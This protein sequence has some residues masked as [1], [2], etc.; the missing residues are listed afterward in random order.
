MLREDLLNTLY[1]KRTSSAEF[2]F[3][4]L[5]APNIH[6]LLTEYD[7]ARIYDITTSVK[8]SSKVAMKIKAIREILRPR[9]F[10]QFAN[11]TNRMCFRFLEDK[12]IVLKVAYK[13]SGLDNGFR[14]MYN[15]QFLKPFVSKTFEVHPSGTVS[16]HE[17]L[18]PITNKEEFLSVI[19]DIF[20]VLTCL[21]G[22]YALE[23]VGTKYFMNWGIRS[24]F[25]V[26]IL[27]YPDL[28]EL[29]G[30]KLY[31]N[32]PIYP[33]TK[34]P[35]C[36]GL[37][38]YDKGFNTLVC[39]CCGKEYRAS[40]LQKARENK[41]IILEGDV[42]MN[43]RIL[44]GNQVVAQSD[45]ISDVIEKPQ[46]F[47]ER[48]STEL[49]PRIIRVNPQPTY[50]PETCQIKEDIKSEGSVAS[51]ATSIPT[52]EIQKPAPKVEGIDPRKLN[53]MLSKYQGEYN[54]NDEDMMIVISLLY[55][56]GVDVSRLTDDHIRSILDSYV[57]AKKDVE[58]SNAVSNNIE[59]VDDEYANIKDIDEVLETEVK[60]EAFIQECRDTTIIID[61]ISNDIVEYAKAVWETEKGVDLTKL[62]KRQ[63][64]T[65]F[66][67]ILHA[68]YMR[69]T[70]EEAANAII[71]YVRNEKLLTPNPVEEDQN[72]DTPKQENNTNNTATEGIKSKFIPT[73]EN[74]DNY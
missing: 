35:V 36:N 45:N 27:D 7:I 68:N 53:D 8:Y 50:K 72:L 73:A 4:H 34:F 22:K 44:R 26:A 11:G 54:L 51:I 21:V 57:N 66:K 12:S 6:S 16:L 9:G 32:R 62:T 74:V 47:I 30:K 42:N 43:V 71:L 67:Y 31:C 18:L 61:D 40:E 60:V 5:T 15:Q 58:A 69:D 29:D 55:S 2:N 33:N 23:D 24:G 39:T 38:D 19:D 37:I 49:R 46:E 65:T 14:E 13:T 25:G 3:E 17:R 48:R 20:N 1:A 56:N 52:R 70:A 28:F 59:P 63:L 10:E 64:I 41:Q